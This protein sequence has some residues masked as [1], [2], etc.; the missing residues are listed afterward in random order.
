[1][2]TKKLLKVIYRHLC[3]NY[4]ADLQHNIELLQTDT[5]GCLRGSVTASTLLWDE[6][7]TV[8]DVPDA[9]TFDFIFAADCLF[10]R[11]YQRALVHTIAVLLRPGGK[12][13]LLAPTRGGTMREFLDLAKDRF[14]ITEEEEYDADVWAAHQKA[15][16]T[17]QYEPDIHFP[18]LLTLELKPQD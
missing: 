9:G 7:L 14:E 4:D 11:Q 16:G 5:P 3:A 6:G 17:E 18:L 8:Q 1:M 15:L 10:F 12:A 2:E 13:F